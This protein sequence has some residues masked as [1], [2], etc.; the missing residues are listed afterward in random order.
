MKNKKQNTKVK[1]LKDLKTVTYLNKKQTKVKNVS[2]METLLFL[3][4]NILYLF[5]V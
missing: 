1:L 2:C 5:R 4:L 3:V